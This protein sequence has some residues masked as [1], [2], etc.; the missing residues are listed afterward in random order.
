MPALASDPLRQS[1][2]AKFPVGYDHYKGSL[3]NPGSNLQVNLFAMF[4]GSRV[5]QLTPKQWK[6]SAPESHTRSEDSVAHLLPLCRSKVAKA[7]RLPPSSQA[8]IG[9]L[10]QRRW[11]PQWLFYPTSARAFSDGFRLVW[12]KAIG[13]ARSGT[14]ALLALSNPQTSK[15]QFRSRVFLIS[16]CKRRNPLN[17]V[18]RCC[19]F[20]V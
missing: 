11:L 20:S 8:H 19:E 4:A 16:G 15:A 7:H 1:H 3:G 9:P 2:T 6:G 18:S 13:Q 12:A 10:E 17:N 5:P 14:A